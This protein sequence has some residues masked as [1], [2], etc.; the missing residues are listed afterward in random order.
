M[1]PG[2][3]IARGLIA[4]FLRRHGFAAVTMPWRRVYILF[5]YRLRQDIIAHERVHLEQIARVGPVRF[6]VSY[7]YW[8]WRVGYEKN[9]WE[10][11]AYARAPVD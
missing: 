1:P 9:P 4:R 10:I 8:L 7:L 3:V 5:E 2:F 6:S 11:E